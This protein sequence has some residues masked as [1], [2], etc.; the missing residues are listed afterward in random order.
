MA[1]EGASV[2]VADVD[3]GR[4]ERVAEA[5][6][7]RG[8]AAVP[9]YVD[10]ASSELVQ[11]L[12]SGVIEAFVTPSPLPTWGRIAIGVLAEATFLAYVFVLGR[13]AFLR[14]HTGDLDPSQLEDRVAAQT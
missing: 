2:V 14:G 12:V 7:G 13:Q 4:A 5:I 1:A 8:F 3:L 11:R 9:A 6:A 10:V